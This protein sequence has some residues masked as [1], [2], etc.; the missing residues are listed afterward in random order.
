MIPLGNLTE[1]VQR[2]IDLMGKHIQFPTT[3]VIA[4]SFAILFSIIDLLD[5]LRLT[6]NMAILSEHHVTTVFRHVNVIFICC[7]H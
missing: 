7:R 5:W 4:E 1:S 2:G 6:Q 3:V